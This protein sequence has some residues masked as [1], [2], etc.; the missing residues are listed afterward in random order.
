M[1]EC[2]D[3]NAN[4]LSYEQWEILPFYWN[5][6]NLSKEDIWYLSWSFNKPVS[7]KCEEDEEGLIALNS[8]VCSYAIIDPDLNTK[9]TGNFPCLTEENFTVEPLYNSRLEVW[10]N[11]MCGTSNNKCYFSF[12]TKATKTKLWSNLNTIPNFWEG[13][14][15][16]WE[17][18]IS[19]TKI[20][21]LQCIDWKW[22]QK[23]KTSEKELCSSTFMLTNPYTVQKTPSGNFK[24]STET[25]SKY[26]YCEKYEKV[27][28]TNNLKCI[29]WNSIDRLLNAITP[30]AYK[31]NEAVN[32]AMEGFINKYSK[33]AVSAWN[34]LKK[35]PGKNIYFVNGPICLW[36]E[37]NVIKLDKPTTIVQ[38][39]WSAEIKWDVNTDN[40]ML[41]TKWKIKFSDP[42]SCTQRQIVKWIFYEEKWI[43]RELVTK[44]KPDRV[45]K[46]GA[47]R[48][49]EWWL[50]IKWV[51]IWDWL[52]QMMEY[53]RS[54]LNGWHKSKTAQTVMNGASVLIE[55]SPSVFTKGSMPPG[56]EDFTTALS[57]YKD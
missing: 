49:T 18:K 10:K 32:K 28:G 33:L 8:M 15:R 13:R 26:K 57:I 45:K 6:D 27:E 37:C 17:Y 54:N 41:L 51:L 42:N 47:K 12:T 7:G 43:E 56:A 52:E 30:S 24:A 53:S 5:L 48:C 25:L 21:Y 20:S 36:S 1:V 40:L 4:Q 29:E 23:D 16:F 39:D 44:N 11:T 55:Y 19:M 50:T 3:I 31:Q 38:I 9:L 22:T 46:Q 35:V 2:Y 14:T 34:W